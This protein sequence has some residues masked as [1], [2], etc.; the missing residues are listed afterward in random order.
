VG[1]TLTFTALSH[2]NA[3]KNRRCRMVSFP[4]SSQRSSTNHL[5]EPLSVRSGRSSRLR[6]PGN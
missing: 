4:P 2:D 6:S 1:R 5:L 3:L